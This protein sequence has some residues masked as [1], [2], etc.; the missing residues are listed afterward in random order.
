MRCGNCW[1]YLGASKLDNATNQRATAVDVN[2]KL[3]GAGRSVALVCYR[4]LLERDMIKAVVG[5]E[6]E[7]KWVNEDDEELNRYLYIVI[8]VPGILRHGDRI[9]LPTPLDYDID[10]L[11]DFKVR[12]CSIVGE[13]LLVYGETQNHYM[14][15]EMH[16]DLLRIGYTVEKPDILLAAQK[17]LLR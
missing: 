10:F 5:V 13:L 12:F 9:T 15:Q 4:V 6:T 7:V 1:G 11:Q 2:F 14:D 16:D 17:A 3:N 8:D